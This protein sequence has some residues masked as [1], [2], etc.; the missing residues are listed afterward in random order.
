PVSIDAS[1][2]MEICSKELIPIAEGSLY[3]KSKPII[4]VSHECP[5][6]VKE[7]AASNKFKLLVHSR[8]EKLLQNLATLVAV[9]TSSN[10]LSYYPLFFSNQFL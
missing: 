10:Q 8:T 5:T 7:E 9:M 2:S 1:K 4:V 6:I 3:E